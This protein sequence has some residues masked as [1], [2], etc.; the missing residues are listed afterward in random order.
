L[1]LRDALKQKTSW[2]F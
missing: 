1:L 2:G